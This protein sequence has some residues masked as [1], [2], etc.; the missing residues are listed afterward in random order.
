MQPFKIYLP[1]S[2]AKFASIHNTSLSDSIMKIKYVT[3]SK[4]SQ[5]FS[6]CNNIILLDNDVH[7]SFNL[8]GIFN[9]HT[10]AVLPNK[11]IVR[12]IREFYYQGVRT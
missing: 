12:D 4:T 3:N 6:E 7:F 11:V 2:F 9:I 5:L 1:S 8:M 10:Y